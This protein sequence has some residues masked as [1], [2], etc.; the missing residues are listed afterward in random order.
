MATSLNE[1]EHVA[2]AE[3]V[4]WRY[5]VLGRAGYSEPE[6]L[7]LAASREVDLRLAERLLAC[8]CPPETALRILV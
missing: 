4:A 3:V 6:A 2:D 1:A 5:E 7:L 8:G